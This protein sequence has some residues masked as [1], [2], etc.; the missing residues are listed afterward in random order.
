MK[1]VRIWNY[2]K[3]IDLINNVGAKMN[4]V[5]VFGVTVILL[6]LS[7][8]SQSY[9]IST[10][11]NME[12]NIVF[13]TDPIF[14]SSFIQSWYGKDFSVDRWIDELDMLKNIGINEVIIQNV[15]DIEK[16]CAV[17]PTELEGYTYCD[18]DMILNVLDAA[19]IVGIKVRVGL[20]DNGEWWT[21]GIYSDSWLEEESNINKKVFDEI[22]KMYGEHSA[23]GGWYIPYEFSQQFI[24]TQIQCDNLN[25]FYRNIGK[26]IKNRSKLD[27]MIS[28]YYNFNKYCIVPLDNWAKKLETV[29]K[30][31]GIDVVALQDS[32]GVKYNNLTNIGVVFIYTKK[33]T[34]KLGIKLFAD[35][36]TFTSIG[37][38]NI[39]VSQGEI[40]KRIESVRPY[41]KG[42]VSFSMNHYQNRNV[43]EQESNYNDYKSYYHGVIGQG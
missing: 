1:N 10:P 32:M 13:K 28:P 29:L 33:A 2:L 7:T 26:E 15:I 12:E 38:N 37:E 11:I 35:T 18:N 5:I 9:A 19:S 23:L 25:E 36:E 24:A 16:K 30:D 14:R 4:K 41:V 21:K 8:Y 43:K 6:I 40:I 17:Y 39:P 34:D 42:Y 20:G 22:F 27:I 3:L 31:T